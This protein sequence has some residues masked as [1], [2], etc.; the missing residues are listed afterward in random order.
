MI[1]S[2]KSYCNQKVIAMIND[3]KKKVKMVDLD[4]LT[5]ITFFA[6]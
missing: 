4:C 1:L 3:T 6:C 2:P 5:I